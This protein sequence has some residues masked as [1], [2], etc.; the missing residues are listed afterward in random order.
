MDFGVGVLGMGMKVGAGVGA[1]RGALLR[2]G[3]SRV[4]A[5]SRDDFLSCGLDS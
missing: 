4:N 3:A 5:C 1:L 2:K